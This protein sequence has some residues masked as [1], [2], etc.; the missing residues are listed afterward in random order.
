MSN[1][2]VELVKRFF[3]AFDRHDEAALLSLVHRDVTFRSLIVE[4]EGGFHGHEG[5]RRYLR[6]LFATFPDFRIQ[7]CD[8]HLVAN[9]AVVEVRVSASGV[10]SGA[11]TALTDWQGLTMHDGKADWWAF[12]R[13]EAEARRAV[14]ERAEIGGRSRWAASA[15][16]RRSS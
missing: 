13:T 5:L 4:V 2:T 12:F 15:H 6:E 8:V 10:A 11:L 7:L 14:D 1:T 9:G 3:A 16:E